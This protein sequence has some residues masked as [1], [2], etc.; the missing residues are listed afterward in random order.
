MVGEFETY[1]TKLLPGFVLLLDEIMVAADGWDLED[2]EKE[3]LA[4]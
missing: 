4:S 2:E 3:G 1:E